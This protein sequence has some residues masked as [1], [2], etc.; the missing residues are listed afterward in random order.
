[1]AGLTTFGLLPPRRR[2]L[3]IYDRLSDDYV[4][5]ILGQI[6]ERDCEKLVE[7]MRKIMEN[8]FEGEIIKLLLVE[9]NAH[10]RR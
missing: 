7:C 8:I 10:L 1:M 4:K 5:Q 2:S 9:D 6:S 3:P